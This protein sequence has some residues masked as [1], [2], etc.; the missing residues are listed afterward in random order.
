M[1]L[2]KLA[3]RAFISITAFG[4][5]VASFTFITQLGV[6]AGWPIWVA[7]LLPLCIDALAAMSLLIYREN[8]DRTA[9]RVAIGAI[10]FSALCNAASHWFSTGLLTRDHWFTSGMLTPGWLLVTVVG[11]VPAVSLGI[12]VHLAT[13][14]DSWNTTT[15][16]NDTGISSRSVDAGRDSFSSVPGSVT[17][18]SGPPPYSESQSSA[19]VATTRTAT[20]S[21][22]M[23][24]AQLAQK[25]SR[26]GWQNL[27][28]D[29][30][31]Q[32]LHVSKRRALDAKKAALDE[33][34]T[35]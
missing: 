18:P 15:K 10:T 30:L 3:R 2:K 22:P 27:S 1:D 9:A 6:Q 14:S 28:G 11:T 25:I 31:A 24:V 21:K 20:T 29:K 32:R 26:N 16:R 12:C 4:A 17:T 5:V 23:T 35:S 19:D 8:K 7:P 13:K 33:T 34:N